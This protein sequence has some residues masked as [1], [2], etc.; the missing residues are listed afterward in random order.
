MARVFLQ[1][2]LPA[3][4]PF[5]FYFLWLRLRGRPVMFRGMALATLAA[6]A[7]VAASLVGLA[8]FGGAPPGSVYVPAHT[9]ADGNFVPGRFEQASPEKQA[10]PQ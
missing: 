8:S 3:L 5:A 10:A 6:V 4:L 9:D 2:V 7:L 1:V